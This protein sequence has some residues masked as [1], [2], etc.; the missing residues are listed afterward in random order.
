MATA[1]RRKAF[2]GCREGFTEPF[3]NVHGESGSWKPSSAASSSSSWR[4]KRCASDGSSGGHG[5]A[6]PSVK[7]AYELR[8][9]DLG[10]RERKNARDKSDIKHT[11]R[12]D[13]LMQHRT[14]TLEVHLSSLVR[15]ILLFGVIPVLVPAFDELKPPTLGLHDGKLQSVASRRVWP[16]PKQRFL[17]QHCFQVCPITDILHQSSRI[18]VSHWEKWSKSALHREIEPRVSCLSSQALPLY[19]SPNLQ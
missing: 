4:S 13:A 15:G 7:G 12:L 5:C 17:A 16:T 19:P 10:F 9:N 11:V 8:P 14:T 1:R 18:I 2:E 6:D 3:S